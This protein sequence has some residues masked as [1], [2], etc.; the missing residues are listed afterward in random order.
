[1]FEET[2]SPK[3]P[4]IL[5]PECLSHDLTCCYPHKPNSNQSEASV[6]D[7]DTYQNRLLQRIP[8]KPLE[9]LVKPKGSVE[10]QKQ[11][12]RNF[13]T[14]QVSEQRFLSNNLTPQNSSKYK[15][16]PSYSFSKLSNP[17]RRIKPISPFGYSCKDS[18]TKKNLATS[19]PNFSKGYP[20]FREVKEVNSSVNLDNVYKSYSKVTP[21]CK[22]VSPDFSKS[23]HKTRFFNN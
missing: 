14:N 20:R 22:V 4:N 12:Q 16:S 18:F 11:V 9:P 13:P 3:R 2:N 7:P 23:Q 8:N 5:L 1:M 10:F 6:M 21:N 17:K 19:I 15:S